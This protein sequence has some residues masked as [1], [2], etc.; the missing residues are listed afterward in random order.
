MK[1]PGAKFNFLTSYLGQP[2]FLRSAAGSSV[3]LCAAAGR[4]KP[5]GTSQISTR[6]FLEASVSSIAAPLRSLGAV[7]DTAQEV[8]TDGVSC[9]APTELPL[10][11]D[12]SSELQVPPPPLSTPAVLSTRSWSRPRA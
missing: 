9:V 8:G 4:A 12:G 6:R 3:A 11:R 10:I 1:A 5:L 2:I 7:V